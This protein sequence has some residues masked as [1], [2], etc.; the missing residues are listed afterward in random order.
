MSNTYNLYLVIID[1]HNKKYYNIFME[2][3]ELRYFLAVAR[4][5]SI[6]RAAENLFITQPNL[7]RQMQNLE[8]ETGQKLFIRGNR[9]VSLTSAGMLLRKRAEEILELHDKTFNELNAPTTEICGDIYI[10]GGESYA[11]QIIAKAARAVRD[12]HPAVRFH[13]FSGDSATIAERLDK[14]LIDFGVFIGVRDLS[15]YDSLRLPLSDTWGVLMRKDSPLSQK[16]KI[17]PEDLWDKQLLLSRQ[18]LGKSGVTEWFNK[19]VE[20]LNVV[21]TGNLLYNTS[22]LVKEGLG[23]AVT[24]DKIINTTGDSDLCFRPLYPDLISHLEIA[25][26]KH[27]AFSR[28]A[29][30]FLGKLR[31]LI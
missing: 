21:G 8:K 3:R 30:V 26:K 15:R 1:G 20:E 11:M 27:E 17:S 6:S 31:N 25:W 19:P 4:E 10:G 29:E 2:L 16:E 24:L 7:S 5:E 12:E 23:Y 28:C 13:L 9:K 22:L 14:G 18:T